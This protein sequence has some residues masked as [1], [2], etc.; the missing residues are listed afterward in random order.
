MV[1]KG[2]K[3]VV[4]KNSL[5]IKDHFNIDESSLRILNGRFIYMYVNVFISKIKFF[6]FVI[7]VCLPNENH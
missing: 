1:K 5:T 3:F 6:T 2:G 7:L 4:Y